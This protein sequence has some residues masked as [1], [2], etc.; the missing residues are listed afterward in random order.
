MERVTRP[1]KTATKPAPP[2]GEGTGGYFTAGDPATGMPAT[3]P[4]YEWFNRVQEEIAGVIEAGGLVLDPAV[5]TQLS[6]AIATMIATLATGGLLAANNLSDVANAAT[7]INNLVTPGTLGNVLTSTGTDW[8]SSAPASPAI[9]T[10]SYDSGN[11]T[12]TPAGSLTLAH[13]LGTTPRFFLT[14]LKCLTAEIGFSVGDLLYTSLTVSES[15]DYGTSIVPDATNLNIRFG[16]S[17]Y[18]YI[19]LDK[20]LGTRVNITNANWALVVRAWA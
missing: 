5:D 14:F 1:T 19:I 3:Q 9:F 6:Q 10:K 2:A 11:Q 15:T 17:T 18:T 7:S 13:Y 16:S 4:G 8:A 12:I 20:G